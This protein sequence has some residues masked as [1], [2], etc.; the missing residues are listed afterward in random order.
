MYHEEKGLDKVVELLPLP[1]LSC[2]LLPPLSCSLLLSLSVSSVC[3]GEGLIALAANLSCSYINIGSGLKHKNR[4]WVATNCK[5]WLDNE[6]E[7]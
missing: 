2:S 5:I 3:E 6:I 7:G 1:P 4:L